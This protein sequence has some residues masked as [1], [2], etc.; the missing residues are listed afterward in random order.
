MGANSTIEWT[1]HTINFWIGCTKV[2][3]GCDRCYAEELARRYDWCE[4]GR[5]K[6]RKRTAPGTWDQPR[7][8]NNRHQKAGTL[9]LVFTNS[10][11]DFFD[12][13]VEQGWRDEAFEIMRATPALVWLVLTKRPQNILR[14]VPGGALPMN[15]C[16]GMTAVAQGEFDRDFPH[17]QEAGQRLGAL[18]L[19]LSYEPALAPL[20]INHFLPSRIHAGHQ[21]SPRTGR[22]LAPAGY[23]EGWEEVEGPADMALGWVIGGGESGRG[24]RG[25]FVGWY[26]DLLADCDEARLPYFQKQMARGAPIP[27]ELMVREWPDVFQRSPQ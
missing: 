22:R 7:I 17:L 1:D 8:L 16:L 18:E 20:R 13:E 27:D 4:W 24:A 12:N 14:M 5:G 23:G 2:G 11:A 6:P 26:R 19:F 3:P 21:V 25:D 9:G 15:V 10:L